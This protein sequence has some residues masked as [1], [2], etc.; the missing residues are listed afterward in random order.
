MLALITLVAMS[1]LLSVIIGAEI[2]EAATIYTW[3][4]ATP[5]KQYAG[6]SFYLVGALMVISGALTLIADVIFGIWTAIQH[7]L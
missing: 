3:D 6:I 1:S 4:A 5:I 7:I 2:A